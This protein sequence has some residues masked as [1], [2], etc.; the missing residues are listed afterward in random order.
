MTGLSRFTAGK[1]PSKSKGS[2]MR[3]TLT[4]A[5]SLALFLGALGA[6][7]GALA[8]GAFP[9]PTLT[10][11][12]GKP[13]TDGTEQ[14]A[15]GGTTEPGA[16]KIQARILRLDA[17][18]LIIT[19]DNNG[20]S[21][22]DDVTSLLTISSEGVIR[23]SAFAGVI[24]SRTEALSLLV[25]VQNPDGSTVEGRSPALPYDNDPPKIS[26]YELVDVDTIRVLFSEDVT[27]R[28]PLGFSSAGSTADWTVSLGGAN[29]PVVNV[30]G[31]GD[32]RLLTLFNDF[33]EDDTPNVLFTVQNVDRRYEDVH[34][35]RLNNDTTRVAV[36][37]IAPD[38]PTIASIAGRNSTQVTA[39][40]T[41]P[42]VVV[43]G[44][45]NGH[46]GQL[47]EETDGVSGLS[48]GDSAVSAKVLG[49]GGSATLDFSGP[50]EGSNDLYAVAWDNASDPN[51]S[52][53]AGGR[54]TLDTT[55]PTVLS[56]EPVD[57]S[58]IRVTF[59]ETIFGTGTPADWKVGGGT[60]PVM[61]VVGQG[62]SRFLQVSGVPAGTEV[63]YSRT[64]GSVLADA[65]GN[66][67]AA[68]SKKTTQNQPSSG[69]TTTPSPA[70]TSTATPTPRPSST[71]TPTPTPTPT[72]TPTA[73]PEPE[74]IE[75]TAVQDRAEA[76]TC[77]EVSVTFYRNGEPVAGENIDIELAEGLEFCDGTSGRHAEAFTDSTGTAVFKILSR[78]D[79][80]I[81]IV[82]WHDKDDDDFTDSN[83]QR[84]TVELKWGLNGAREITLN[85]SKK[86][87][88][89]GRKIRLH[90]TTEAVVRRCE[91]DAAIDIVRKRRGRVK[92]LDTVFTRA[93][94]SFRKRIRVKRNAF[95][96]ARANAIGGCDEAL[97]P[98]LRI[99]VK[100]LRK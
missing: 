23:G 42:I 15:F 26:G 34:G 19:T 71:A 99:R 95:Y 77:Q 11:P 94:G 46:S 73:A 62:N 79:Q 38:V 49:S 5:V 91:V 36:D 3:R 39:N 57:S 35:R 2:A 50:S 45:T 89:R 4:I 85:T 7:T 61:S 52:A 86:L 16:T 76:G 88:K 27:Y 25:K 74:N 22:N 87:V 83:E 84:R 33:D 54:Y 58:F 63:A 30:T 6:P 48:S 69:S 75:A 68:A 97:S 20:H 13:S 47:F 60:Y 32:E 31:A 90:G 1:T 21:F 98:R 72:S 18:G 55:A 59:T 8:A 70:P 51:R 41:N 66:A 10:D 43:S 96:F 56:A 65:V 81:A 24:P 37:R 9:A 80:T 100:P 67:V 29:N 93:D 82:A 78:T 28:T 17:D 14:V 12:T 92:V 64:S 44:L 40:E 53:G